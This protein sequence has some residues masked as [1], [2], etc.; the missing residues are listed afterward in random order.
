MAMHADTV[1]ACVTFKL[2]EMPRRYEAPPSKPICR[3]VT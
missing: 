3:Y 2:S 1:M